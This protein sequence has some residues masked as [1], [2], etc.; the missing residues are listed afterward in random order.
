MPPRSES[1][2]TAH[3]AVMVNFDDGSP[4]NITCVFD[5]ICCV[6]LG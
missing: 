4:K 5:K 6:V 2:V 3:T 1:L